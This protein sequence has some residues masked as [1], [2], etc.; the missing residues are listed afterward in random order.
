MYEAVG[1]ISYFDVTCFII[2]KKVVRLNVFE[3]LN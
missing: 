2:P 3:T 1:N